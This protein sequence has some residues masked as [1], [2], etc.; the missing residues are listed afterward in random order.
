MFDYR[1]VN[2]HNQAQ[3]NKIKTML[4]ICPN[5]KILI[6]KLMIC[7]LNKQIILHKIVK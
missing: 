5:N 1:N 2:N 6:K 7:K 3:M 4:I